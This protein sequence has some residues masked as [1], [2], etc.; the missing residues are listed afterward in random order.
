MMAF[1]L[2]LVL[3]AGRATAAGRRFLIARDPGRSGSRK[4]SPSKKKW[5]QCKNILGKGREIIN[6]HL[7]EFRL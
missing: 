1:R 7:T 6:L 5:L 3:L 4:T 2:L